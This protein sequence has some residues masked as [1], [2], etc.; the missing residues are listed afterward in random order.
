MIDIQKVKNKRNN[1]VVAVGIVLNLI[2]GGVCLYDYLKPTRVMTWGDRVDA[3]AM[4]KDLTS[5]APDRLGDSMVLADFL[6]DCQQKKCVVKPYRIGEEANLTTS[7]DLGEAIL[8]RQIDISTPVEPVK[9]G[10]LGL[11]VGIL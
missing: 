8:A 1:I 10:L 2:A 4:A 6:D 7:K 11:G 9:S 5:R 3:L